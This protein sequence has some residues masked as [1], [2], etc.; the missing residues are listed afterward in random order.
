MP[1]PIIVLPG[2]YGSL[3]NDAATAKTVWLTLDAILHSGQTLDAIRLD[4]GDPARIVAGEILREVE[5][6]GRWSPNVYK[7]L[8]IF[9]GSLGYSSDEVVPFG[10]DWLP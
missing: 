4:T 7:G 3:L 6:I 2:Y 1:N 8:L 10:L 9:L 5:I